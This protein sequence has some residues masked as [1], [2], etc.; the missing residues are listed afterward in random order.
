MALAQRPDF[1]MTWRSQ[2]FHPVIFNQCHCY[3]VI[4]RQRGV[5]FI[6]LNVADSKS[7]RAR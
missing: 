7:V 1:H 4:A 3:I 2:K 5:S 6:L